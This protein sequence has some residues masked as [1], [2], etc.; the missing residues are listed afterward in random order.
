[1]RWVVSYLGGRLQIV[2]AFHDAYTG[3][4][5]AL[6]TKWGGFRTRSGVHVGSSRQALR[7]LHVACANGDCSWVTNGMPD[8][9]GII[10]TMHR[11]RV[12]EIFVGSD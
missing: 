8:A 2:F 3:R 5:Q 7:S 1:M 4:V 12:A 11:G 10:F 9:P 6:I